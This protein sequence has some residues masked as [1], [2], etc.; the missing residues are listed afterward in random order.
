MLILF[1]FLTLNLIP[2][3]CYSPANW[4][5]ISIFITLTDSLSLISCFLTSKD[6][7]KKLNIF[8]W[9]PWLILEDF[10]TIIEI[11]ICIEIAEDFFHIYPWPPITTPEFFNR[12]F[13]INLP[14]S[15]IYRPKKGVEGLNILSLK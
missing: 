4:N 6:I 11:I 7:A 9:F 8:S 3:W 2:N 5:K 13:V 12:F 10:R 15:L 1:H 14:A